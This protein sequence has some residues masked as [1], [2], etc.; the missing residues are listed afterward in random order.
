MGVDARAW[1]VAVAMALATE[2]ADPEK[3]EAGVEAAVAAPEVTVGGGRV[4]AP[5]GGAAGLEAV[6]S[7]AMERNESSAKRR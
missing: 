7:A 5:E 1:V 3:V 4:T 6:A 2:M